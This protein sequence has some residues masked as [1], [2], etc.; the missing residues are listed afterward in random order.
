MQKIAPCLWFDT[1]AEEAANFYVSLFKNSKVL[2]VTRYPGVGQEITGKA[3][4]SILTV[5]FELD[6]QHYTALNGGP[7]FKFSEAFSLQVYCESQEEIDE[8]WT[9][10]TADGGQESQCGWLKDKYGMS[11][12]IVP[13]AIEKLMDDPNKSKVNA[14]MAALLKM[15]KLVI[16]DLQAAYDAA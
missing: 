14:V 2:K 1:Q 11:W 4:G 8:Y 12:Q 10:F 3:E 15:K 7:Q 9:K 13:T 16:A 5:E 6:G